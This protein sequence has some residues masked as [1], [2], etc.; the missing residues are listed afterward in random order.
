MYARRGAACRVCASLS[1]GVVG[2]QVDSVVLS[3]HVFVSFLS[4]IYLLFLLVS[5][6]CRLLSVAATLESVTVVVFLSLYRGAVFS[7]FFSMC[8]I[9]LF[10][11]RPQ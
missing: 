8:C 10:V 2:G 3:A 4:L 11:V 1:V 6:L 5:A 9:L 7:V